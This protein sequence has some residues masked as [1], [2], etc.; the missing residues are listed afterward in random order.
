MFKYVGRKW[1]VVVYLKYY[2][3]SAFS[4]QTFPAKGCFVSIFFTCLIRHGL[5]LMCVGKGRIGKVRIGK[6]RI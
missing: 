3:T 4:M 1:P 5:W 6:G 2:S